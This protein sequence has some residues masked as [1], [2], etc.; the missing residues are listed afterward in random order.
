MRFEDDTDRFS[1]ARDV[2][3]L[4]TGRAVWRTWRLTLAVTNV[5]RHAL[6]MPRASDR[7][8][9][10]WSLKLD[11]NR[12]SSDFF[13]WK[14]RCH[15]DLNSSLFTEK[16][17]LSSFVEDNQLFFTSPSVVWYNRVW[18]TFSYSQHVLLKLDRAHFDAVFSEVRCTCSRLLS[19]DGCIHRLDSSA[20]LHKWFMRLAD[21]HNNFAVHVQSLSVN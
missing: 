6:F 11:R 16:C 7:H 5:R 17:V 9:T 8:S 4:E 3:E 12:Q 1:K 21:L 10:Q 15:S 18:N 19:G 20:V 14:R 13:N 2:P